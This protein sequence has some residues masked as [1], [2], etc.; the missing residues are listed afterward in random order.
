MARQATLGVSRQTILS[1]A[2]SASCLEMG[3]L[4]GQLQQQSGKD[5]SGFYVKQSLS[6]LL[7]SE[8]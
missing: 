4:N 6:G 3:T 8:P 7:G 5:Q 1:K 2:S